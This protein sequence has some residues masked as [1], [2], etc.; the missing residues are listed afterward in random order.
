MSGILAAVLLLSAVAVD[1]RLP[2]GNIICEKID[3]DVVKVR[4]DLRDTEGGWFYWAMRVTGAAGRTLRFDF[5]DPYG[6]GPVGVRGPVVSTDRGKT[7]AFPLDG[8]ASSNSFSW[9][10]PAGQDEVWFYEC[11]PYLPADWE[12][13]LAAHAADRGTVFETGVLCRTRKGRAVPNARFGCLA[14]SPRYR[15]LLTSRHHCSET[16]ATYVLEGTCAAFFG[17]DDLG[18]WLRANVELMVVP[19]ID[20]DGSADGDQ[21][22]NRRPHDHNRDYGEWVHV[23]PKAMTEWVKAHA[24]NKVDAYVDIHCPWIRGKYNEWLYTPGKSSEVPF[25]RPGNEA[26]FSRLLERLQCG[27]IRYRAQ[28]DLPFGQSW[29]TNNN[30][31]KGTTCIKWAGAN[32]PSLRLCRTFEVPFANAN[33]AVVTPQVCRD[34]GRD[35]AR[36]Y[37]EFL[38]G[39]TA[40]V[41]FLGDVMCSGH[42]LEPYRRKDGT[43][44][45]REIFAG[46]KPLFAGSDAVIAN[47]ETPIAPKSDDLTRERWSFNSPREFALAVKDAG[48][49][50]V[51]TANNHCLDRGP[52][53]VQAT[54]AALDALGLP[55]TG[56]FATPEAAETPSYLDVKGFR[57]G[58]HSYTY[59]S[60]AFSNH[61]YLNETNRFMVN[62]FQK[63]E[64]S[65]PAWHHPDN[66]KL[67]VYERVEDHVAERARLKADV[68]RM[69]ATRPDFVVMGMHTGGQYNPAATKYTK[70]LAAFLTGCGVD[71][72][73][74]SH[75][76]VVHGRDFTGL[77]EN[78]LIAY[79]L[80][81][82]NSVSGVW[83]A[84]K[85]KMAD[86]S[87]AWHVYLARDAKG[88][89][90]VER[91]TFSVLKILPGAREGR[92]RV[93]P[94]AQLWREEQDAAKKSALARDILEIARRFAGRDYSAAP[95]ADEFE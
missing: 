57:L 16:M 28:D 64:L 35:L 17:D 76:H 69:R 65:D 10:F 33:G 58:L 14:G 39:E 36:C 43:Y 55:H 61:Q 95:I 9:I 8:K 11:H 26:R 12:A 84:P 29:N 48:I 6:G 63:Q 44:D 25:I 88:K 38:A 83:I 20:F 50:F 79:S 45:F 71:L 37:R 4:Q 46:V 7:F 80:G 18:R 31:T 40:K 90:K 51:F 89:A 56:T 3:G 21:G 68:A 30:Y 22:K 85:D 42:M 32:W 5:T 59:G 94:A 75:E 13:F 93:M 66:D 24:D 60:N 86:Y 62:F 67:P 19:F 72:V 54:V 41:T 81:N 34:L 78:R 91:T 2:A 53:G 77:A 73:V 49:D 82:F 92:I 15:I 87:V 23:E 27:S 52:K 47:L 1:D 74:G 70:E